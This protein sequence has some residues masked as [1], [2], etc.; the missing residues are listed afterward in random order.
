VQRPRGETRICICGELAG[1]VGG[2]P[3]EPALRGRLGR[4]L[5]AYLVLNRDRAVT[6]GEL[7]DR[8]WDESPPDSSAT[9]LNSLL[10]R[11]R[12]GLGADVLQGRS[13]LRLML[14][15]DAWIDVEKARSWVAAAHAA[16][17]Q[18]R[19]AEAFSRARE[20]L[21][22]LEQGLLVDVET[23]WLDEQRRELDELAIG[24]LECVA[25][26]GP[27]LGGAE[28][29]EGDRA[30][31]AVIERAPYRETG[32]RLLM[33]ALERRGNLAE[34]LR[35]YE[36]CRALLGEELGATPGPELRQLHRRLLSEREPP[37]PTEEP[38]GGPLPPVLRQVGP[39]VGRG[40]ERER[41]QRLWKTALGGR[42]S[43]ALIAGEP[44]IGKTRL[45]GHV[46][47]GAQG[48]GAL[49][50]YGRCE[51]ELGV[52][53]QPWVEAL[54]EAV[55]AA[56][57]DELRAHV[58]EHGGDLTRLTPG[59]ARRLPGVAAPHESD[60]ETERYL[61]FG[62]VVG[63]L[64]RISRKRPVLLVLDDLHAADTGTLL[65]LRHLAG[66]GTDPRLLILAAY[67]SSEVAPGGPVHGTLADLHRHGDVERLEL[68]GFDE[69]EVV[70]LMEAA[71]GSEL[72]PAGRALA[73]EIWRETDGNPF[74]VIE[75]LHHLRESGAVDGRLEVTGSLAGVGLPRSVREVITLRVQRLHEGALGVLTAGAVIGREFDLD[76][77]A[78]VS[79]LPEDDVLDLLDS[80]VDAALLTEVPE[81][82]GRFSFVHALIG[83]TLYE[84]LG[85][86][87]RARL[88]GRVGE[89]LEQLAGEDPGPLL[90]E[91]ARHWSAAATSNALKS[92]DYCR[93]AAARALKNLAPDEAVRWSAKALSV[94]PTAAVGD[95]LRC[96]L[97]IE[98][99][100]AQRQTRD[101]AHRE[102]LLE[103]AAAARRLRDPDRL[104]RAA[105]ASNRHAYGSFG[106]VDEE[107]AELYEAALV[108]LPKSDSRR[109]AHVLALLAAERT[110]HPDAATRRRLAH[111][112]I[113]LGRRAGDPRTLAVALQATNLP[114][115]EPDTVELRRR[116]AAEG[117]EIS[118][119]LGAPR[120]RWWATYQEQ[121]GAFEA[122]DLPASERS[123]REMRRLAD[124]TG[125][126]TL[127]WMTSQTEA[128][129]LTLHGRYPEAEA[130]AKRA[131]D[132]G[133][134]D[135]LTVYIPQ[136]GLIRFQQGRLHELT[137]VFRQA[138]DSTPIPAYMS[139]HALALIEDGRPD[140]AQSVVRRT[141]AGELT[142]LPWFLTGPALAQLTLA[143]A[144]LDDRDGATVV[145][146]HVAP[147]AHLLVFSN[148]V[149]YGSM[150]LYAGTLARLCGRYDESERH[151]QRA[152]EVNERIQA[153]FFLARTHLET[154][155]VYK[156]RGQADDRIRQAHHLA[157]AVDLAREHD[158]ARVE[159]QA[160]QLT[161]AAAAR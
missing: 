59:L 25:A 33:E 90:G 110:L 102:T 89:T 67:R 80:A 124:E 56:A 111:Q 32:Y 149:T 100:E 24:A 150:S 112:A 94:S 136:L 95:D 98:L 103:A 16:L 34:A 8:L 147:W 64:S 43:I 55:A 62:A 85:P 69:A 20:A 15:P 153:P 127:E 42:R 139:G 13:T 6:R 21:E 137:E 29:A 154:A 81:R 131:A 35:V 30:A 83:H 3:L 84:N 22:V 155:R 133:E 144:E 126:P 109:R 108:A 160:L 132:S 87:R 96:D 99:G 119:E 1:T 141:V 117:I 9:T 53:Y 116:H 145:Y 11:M 39:Y 2:R 49:V 72:D 45:C 73:A 27:Q 161:A 92:I 58:A 123:L 79:L 105:I 51:E 23:R 74:F 104:F 121:I 63:F 71:A 120:I 130:I 106:G 46:A 4:L 157:L 146:P 148:V 61:L 18:E 48:D 7:V 156:E 113:E 31:R 54:A 138:S 125:D 17:E 151:L 37:R 68:T 38:A 70:S 26:A 65:L 76:L 107:R 14:P 159:S 114:L 41:L 88:H 57:E 10:S 91:L 152:A 122:D 28:A 140:E 50:L 143:C 128:A 93:R 118:A 82:P 135:A 36:Q 115:W 86:A 101:G 40:A 47:A 52:P 134:R 77:V 60:P 12:S 5:F 142:A 129:V 44:G 158:L 97:L 19:P 75:L 66:A 78:P